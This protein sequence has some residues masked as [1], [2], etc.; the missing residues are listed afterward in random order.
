[1]DDLFISRDKIEARQMQL[2]EEIDNQTKAANEAKNM[3]Q[4]ER[5]TSIKILED[6]G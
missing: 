4:S 1:M 3:E 5:D 6:F 2:R